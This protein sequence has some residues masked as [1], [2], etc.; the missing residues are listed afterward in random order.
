M[1]KTLKLVMGLFLAALVM[2]FSLQNAA[3]VEISF[4]IWSAAMPRVIVYFG[5]L[6]AG[7]LIGWLVRSVVATRV[8]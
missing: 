1:F 8:L 7:I 4:L 3:T 6:A 5:I 2:V